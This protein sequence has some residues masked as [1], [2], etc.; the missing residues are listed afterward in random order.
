[1]SDWKS[2]VLTYIDLI[3]TKDFAAEPD[4]RATDIM[5]RMHS[6]VHQEVTHHMPNHDHCYIWNDSLLLL[7]YLDTPYRNTNIGAIIRE[8]DDLK[9]KIDKLCKSFA[10]SVRGQV[11]PHE[12]HLQ[13]NAYQGQIGDQPRVIMLKASSY[14]MANCFLIEAELG[15]KLKRPWYIDGRIAKH[16]ETNQDVSEHSIKMLPKNKE[17]AVFAYDGYLW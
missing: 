17:R 4:S 9:K 15:K 8:A 2:C 13:A 12:P 16:L 3:G 6:M 10:I 11:F 1:M 7:S 5:R 14:A